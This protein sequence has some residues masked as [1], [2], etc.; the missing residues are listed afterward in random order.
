MLLP[1]REIEI[2]TLADKIR[3]LVEP[4]LEG[5][6]LL[7]DSLSSLLARK[8]IRIVPVN[9]EKCQERKPLRELKNENYKYAVVFTVASSRAILEIHSHSF[10]KSVIF[11]LAT[12]GLPQEVTT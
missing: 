12:R 10:T 1:Q 5:G 9:D 2:R 7:I 4:K 3:A 6:Q 11:Y 8:G